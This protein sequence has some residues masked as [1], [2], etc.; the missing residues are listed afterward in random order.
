MY[1]VD[2]PAKSPIIKDKIR[3]NYYGEDLFDIVND[4]E[5]LKAVILGIKP[6]FRT[7]KNIGIS[8]GLNKFEYQWLRITY[9]LEKYNYLNDKNLGIV[10][11]TTNHSQ[12]E[13]DVK[14]T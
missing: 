13:L 14:N 4:K 1:G 5:K 9:F 7:I 10:I 11:P 8:V 2:N 12:P 6:E 3:K